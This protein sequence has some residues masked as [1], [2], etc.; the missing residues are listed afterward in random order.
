MCPGSL[1]I[2]LKMCFFAQQSKATKHTRKATIIIVAFPVLLFR[3][4]I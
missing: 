3:R 4:I 2:R 1:P